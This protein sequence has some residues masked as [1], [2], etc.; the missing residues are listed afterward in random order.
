MRWQDGGVKR[1]K[2]VKKVEHKTVVKNGIG[3]GSVLAITISWSVNHSIIWAI[4]HGCFSWL[5]VIYYAII[6]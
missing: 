2:R 5:Y 1:V 4:I 3:F 6:R